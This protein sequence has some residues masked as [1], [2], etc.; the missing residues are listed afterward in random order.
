[1]AR[2]LELRNLSDFEL[3]TLVVVVVVV[4]ISFKRCK[5]MC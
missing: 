3:R 1:M 4:S 2:E 5:G